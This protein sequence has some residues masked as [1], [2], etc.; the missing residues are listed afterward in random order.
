MNIEVEVLTM[1]T[2]DGLYDSIPLGENGV[3]KEVVIE[4]DTGYFTKTD[5]IAWGRK[6][7]GDKVYSNVGKYLDAHEL[8]QSFTM[9]REAKD[10]PSLG[11]FKLAIEI[12]DVEIN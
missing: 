1:R 12:L 11:D 8:G 9:Q 5:I 10:L 3:Y 7:Y 4:Y 6:I 2:S